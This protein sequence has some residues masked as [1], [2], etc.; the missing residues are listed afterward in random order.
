MDWFWVHLEVWSNFSFLHNFQWITFPTQSCLILY[1]FCA[2]LL[3]SLNMWSTV[4]SLVST[5]SI[6]VI[7]LHIMNFCLYIISPYGIISCFFEKGFSFSLEVSISYPFPGHWF[8]LSVSLYS[9]SFNF[10]WLRFFSFSFLYI[11]WSSH[12]LFHEFVF[13]IFFQFLFSKINNFRFPVCPRLVV[14]VVGCRY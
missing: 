1:S 8:S 7:P 9:L 2:S 6:L 4:S 3:H 12:A 14:V 13:W 11:S 10:P 5:S